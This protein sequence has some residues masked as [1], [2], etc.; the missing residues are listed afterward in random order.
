M[1][2]TQCEKCKAY[3]IY[4]VNTK[5]F[6]ADCQEREKTRIANAGVSVKK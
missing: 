1:R 3:A 2:K 6:C 5:P 4:Y